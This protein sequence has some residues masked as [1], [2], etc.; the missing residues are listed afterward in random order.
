LFL[1][2]ESILGLSLIPLLF[3][4]ALFIALVVGATYDRRKRRDEPKWI[5]FGVGLVAI[6]GYGL[7][8]LGWT[9]AGAWQLISSW[10]FWTPA[11]EY[12]GLGLAYT[13]VEFFFDIRRAAAVY[14][15][16][17][18]KAITR[19]ET[20]AK[21]DVDGKQITKLDKNGV[22]TGI[23]LVEEKRVSELLRDVAVNGKASP[24]FSTA[25]AFAQSFV[26]QL[27][28]DNRIVGLVLPTNEA[29]TPEPKI[30]K[31]ELAEHAGA[32]TLFWPFY[33]A[34]LVLGDLLTELF[35]MFAA[36][37]VRISSRFVKLTF[38]D[39]FKF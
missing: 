23:V 32:W 27:D 29:V 26:G 35:D 34:S 19:K 4:I 10:T 6:F 17:W 24:Y 11:L 38:A 9:L 15:E 36:L 14:R 37:M 8:T 2:F 21:F 5:I 16:Q 12:I 28:Y 39:V 7:S 33:L 3:I 1:L 31:L 13:I 25:R 22:G 30:S 18:A 20:V